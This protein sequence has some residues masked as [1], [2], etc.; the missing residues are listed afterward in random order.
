[1][2]LVCVAVEDVGE[3][4]GEVRRDDEGGVVGAGLDALLGLVLVH[5]GPAQLRVLLQLVVD[6]VAGVGVADTGDVGAGVVD[7]DGHGYGAR[8]VVGVP[9]G[10][11]VDPGVE[12]GDEAHAERDDDRDRVD[13]YSLEVAQEDAQGCLHVVSRLSSVRGWGVARCRVP[14]GRGCGWG[15]GAGCDGGV[16]ASCLRSGWVR[17]GA[18]RPLVVGTGVR[19]RRPAW[20]WGLWS[21][22][23]VYRLP[24][25]GR[26]CPRL[27]AATA[28]F[29]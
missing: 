25:V 3:R 20:A 12:G 18:A 17:P 6:H 4:G 14:C 26:L 29:T 8:V 1:M 28:K 13:G 7:G 2:G 23:E 10:Q 27:H 16:M 15:W 21:G 5:E 9:V 22:V 19:V 11:D 24:I